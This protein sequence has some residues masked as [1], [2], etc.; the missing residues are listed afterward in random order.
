MMCNGNLQCN[1]KGSG[2]GCGISWIKDSSDAQNP[3]R[4]LLVGIQC[5]IMHITGQLFECEY[6]SVINVIFELQFTNH[7]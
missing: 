2:N 7:N 4:M 3:W 1:L 5:L 6:F